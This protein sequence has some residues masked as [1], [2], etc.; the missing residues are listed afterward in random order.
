MRWLVGL[1]GL[2]AVGCGGPPA[3]ELYAAGEAAAADTSSQ[4]VALERFG[5]LLRRYPR[6]ALAPKALR[7]MAMISQQRGEMQK[8]IEQYQRLL[9]EYPESD[10]GD[11][12]QFMIAFIYD[13][14][15]RDYEQARVAYQAFIDRYPDSELAAS[16]QRLLAN[17]GRAPEEWVEFQDVAR[18][19]RAP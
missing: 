4:A 6:H 11:E 19:A 3:E 18:P 2:V 17:I 9:R 13:E 12:A 10:Q 5:E 7:Q 8:A 15:L 14:S 1:V 16:A